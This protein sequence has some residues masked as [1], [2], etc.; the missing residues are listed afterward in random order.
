MT[1]YKKRKKKHAPPHD[2]EKVYERDFYSH[3]LA[4]PVRYIYIYNDIYNLVLLSDL[5]TQTSVQKEYT[6]VKVVPY[7][8][9]L[10]DPL[11]V[12]AGSQGTLAL[13]AQVKL[14]TLKFYILLIKYIKDVWSPLPSCI[15]LCKTELTTGIQACIDHSCLRKSLYMYIIIFYTITYLRCT[16]FSGQF[17]K[18]LHLSLH[19]MEFFTEF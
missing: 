12:S 11:Y 4:N 6:T 13:I 7:A 17:L 18:R 15:E 3:V 16:I 2:S 5:Q 19:F 9:T 1:I 10:K 8:I 14:Y